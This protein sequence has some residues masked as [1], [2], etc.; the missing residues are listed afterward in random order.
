MVKKELIIIADYSHTS[1]I[2]LDEVCHI[3]NIS[4]DII[5]SLIE[6][7]IIHPKYTQSEGWL[8]DLSDLKRIKRALRLQ[9][10]LEMNLQSVAIVLRLMDEM[11]NLRTELELF[12]KHF[13]RLS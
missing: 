8:F 1:S 9:H 3:C 2:H 4:S 10:D 13:T 5:N 11:E 7:E 6:Y 12:E